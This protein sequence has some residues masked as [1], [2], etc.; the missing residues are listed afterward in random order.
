M[1]R[2]QNLYLVTLLVKWINIKVIHLSEQQASNEL[3]PFHI[4]LPLNGLKLIESLNW[5]GLKMQDKMK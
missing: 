3:S 4:S 2:M 5:Q 1:F